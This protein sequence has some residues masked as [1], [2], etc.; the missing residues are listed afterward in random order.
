MEKTPME[1]PR[2][3]E[4]KESDGETAL[5]LSQLEAMREENKK[6]KED[7]DRILAEKKEPV[8]GPT[9]LKDLKEKIRDLDKKVKVFLEDFRQEFNSNIQQL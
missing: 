3:T 2:K 6:L 4:K 1:K 5:L 9:R 8:S 7:L